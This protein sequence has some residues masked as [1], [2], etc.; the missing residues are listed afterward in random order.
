M[1]I[2]PELGNTHADESA[3]PMNAAPYVLSFVIPSNDAMEDMEEW[4]REGGD[5]I[6]GTW[7]AGRV[8]QGAWYLSRGL[9]EQSE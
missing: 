1:R 8:S 7:G 2:V 6:P 5:G 3:K 9:L 4:K